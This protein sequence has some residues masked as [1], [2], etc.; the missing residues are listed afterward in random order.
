MAIKYALMRPNKNAPKANV[1]FRLPFVF[2]PWVQV[3]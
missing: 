1:Y 3:N 2:D